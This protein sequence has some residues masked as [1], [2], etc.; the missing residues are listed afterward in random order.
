MLQLV[1]AYKALCVCMCGRNRKSDTSRDCCE[2]LTF[3]PF[4]SMSPFVSYTSHQNI[5]IDI[6]Q[7]AFT[8]QFL[9]KH[10]KVL[11]SNIL[12]KKKRHNILDKKV[13][14]R[15][16]DRYDKVIQPN[17]VTQFYKI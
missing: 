3:F 15:Y 12:C 10:N 8:R 9:F 4:H 5:N 7:T 6:T 13:L 14:S 2:S 16:C 1:T 11:L 17:E